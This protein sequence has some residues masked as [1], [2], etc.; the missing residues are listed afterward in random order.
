MCGSM[1][2]IQSP[3]AEIRRGNKKRKN[4]SAASGP[5]FTILWGYVEEILLLNK[6]FSNIVDTLLSCED[7]ARQSC[8][9]LP[10]W[11]IFGDFWVLHFQGRQCRR[12]IFAPWFLLSSFFFSSPNLSGR[13]LDVYDT[14]TYGLALVRI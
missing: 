5:K 4:N 11:P 10:R 1:A 13:K 2:D 14:S 8:A 6:F 12:H 7:I 3:T 9:L